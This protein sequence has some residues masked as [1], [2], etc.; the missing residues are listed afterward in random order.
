MSN[1][2]LKIQLFCLIIISLLTSIKPCF[3]YSCDECSSEEYGNCTKCLNS[4]KLVDGTC[5]CH[6]S[7]CAICE[8]G[9]AGLGLCILCK[10]GY[11]L[12]Y[13]NCYCEIDFCERCSE[14]GCLKCNTGFYYNSSSKMCEE[15]NTKIECFDENCDT[16]YS[17][18]DGSCE[19]CKDG[20]VL[21]K[22]RC[23]RL[24]DPNENGECPSGYYKIKNNNETFCNEK[25]YGLNCTI[26]YYYSRYKCDSSQCLV[27]VYNELRIF[28]DCD[29]SDFC[30]ID[31]CL[32][33]YTEDECAICQQGR[34]L[35]GGSCK[36]CIEGCSSCTNSETCEYCLSGFELTENNTCQK[37]D[38]F[39]FNIDYYN[40]YKEKKNL[41]KCKIYDN[42]CKECNINVTCKICNDGYALLNNICTKCSN[43]NCQLCP[44]DINYCISA[45]DG[46]YIKD[47]NVL[48]C[49]DNCQKCT[50][51][52]TCTK[53]N[54][55]YS[56][57]DGLCADYGNVCKAK[58]QNCNYCIGDKCIECNIGYNFNKKGKCTG[59]FNFYP[60]IIAFISAG[61][62]ILSIICCVNNYK[63][64][65]RQNENEVVIINPN[66][67]RIIVRESL[68]SAQSD[69]VINEKKFED[70]FEEQKLKKEKGEELC[71]FCKNK[72]GRYVCDCGCIVCLEHSK[73]KKVK[74]GKKFVKT[75]FVCK[76]VVKEVKPKYTCEICM[77]NVLCVAH[78][79]CN[80][81]LEVCKKC[82][83]KCK[84]ESDRCPAC[85]KHL[86]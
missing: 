1:N 18:K 19:E 25:C 36:K 17:K 54:S 22:G 29:D 52:I 16:C 55:Y 20:F 37:T 81:A 64:R 53:C 63:K 7:G 60:I 40:D 34:Y 38:N 49:G 10:N 13:G 78:F 46:Y 4:F 27:C 68:N 28:S 35:I 85:R 41:E 71:Q 80:C 50:D 14:N 77:E 51:E 44:D 42:N 39:D 62:I 26:P 76:K 9:Y 69:R 30:K 43:E 82:F 83:V 66:N 86:D 65:Q 6:D 24:P 56:L 47:G 12:S 8:S 21:K 72:P 48:K 23:N 15:N 59:K 31:G 70:Q 79:E 84:I 45:K 3:E 2:F 33:C 61:F 75:C 11:K 67:V 57:I 73:L 58:F 74:R 32:N 5:P